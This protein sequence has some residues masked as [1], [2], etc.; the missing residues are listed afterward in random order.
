MKSIFLCGVFVQFI[1]ACQADELEQIFQHPPDAARPQVYW[2]RMGSNISS[3][4]ITRDLEAL[5]V[6]GFGGP[7]KSFPAWFVRG[8]PRPSAWRFTFSTWNYFNKNSPL[9]SSGL[10][11]P[12]KL[13]ME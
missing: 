9:V 12:V 11:G 1:T 10:L 5:K 6:E 2:F 8:Q 7:L 4:G 13:S 3:N